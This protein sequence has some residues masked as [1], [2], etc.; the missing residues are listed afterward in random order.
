MHPVLSAVMVD[1][2]GHGRKIR[3]AIS[4][5]F[6][7]VRLGDARLLHAHV[8]ADDAAEFVNLGEI[9]ASIHAC[10]PLQT[11]CN[12]GKLR[13]MRYSLRFPPA[14]FPMR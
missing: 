14:G 11:S 12:S 3:I 10:T 5:A 6:N 9:G 4:D 13:P 8:R 1:T 7:M 2:Q